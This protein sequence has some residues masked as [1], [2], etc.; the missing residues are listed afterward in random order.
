LFMKFIPAAAFP[1]TVCRDDQATFC[2]LLLQ[3]ILC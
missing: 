3:E 2:M 1:V